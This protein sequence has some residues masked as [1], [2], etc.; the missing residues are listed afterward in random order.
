MQRAFRFLGYRF[1]SE[2]EVLKYLDRRGYSAA[3]AETITAKLRS[4]NYLNDEKF[5]RNWAHSRAETRGYG[6]KRIE[7]ELKIKGIGQALI[8]EVIRETFGPGDE[9]ENA[10][11][12]L[13]NRFRNKKLEDVKMRRR[14]AAFLDR[15][16]YSH[17]VIFELLK[18]P[19][20]E[21]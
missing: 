15:H 21:D 17:R 13:E 3:I 8:Q 12:L 16:G 4:L 9:S 20:E 14:A 6:P 2:A 5:A 7:Q 1:R 10:K 18:R 19:L 11:K